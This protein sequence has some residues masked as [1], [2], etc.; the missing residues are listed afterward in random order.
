MFFPKKVLKTGSLHFPGTASTY[1]GESAVVR[2][3]E[4]ENYNYSNETAWREN[5]E[6]SDEVL[7]QRAGPGLRVH[8]LR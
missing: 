5:V 1:Q 7:V 3:V 8:V 4:A 6:Q 2:E